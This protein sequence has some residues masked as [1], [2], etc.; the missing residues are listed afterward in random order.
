VFDLAEGELRFVGIPLQYGTQFQY[1]MSLGCFFFPQEDNVIG[2]PV[3]K[4]FWSTHL[5]PIQ[6]TGDI[7][8]SS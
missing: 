6:D 5:F 2:V 3:D 1:T 8:R 4:L 7:A